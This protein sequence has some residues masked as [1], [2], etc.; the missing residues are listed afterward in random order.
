MKFLII[1]IVALSVAFVVGAKMGIIDVPGLS[2]AAKKAKGAKGYATDADPA[3][4]DGA[5]VSVSAKPADAASAGDENPAA[6]AKQPPST[7]APKSPV[8]PLAGQKSLARVWQKV[9]AST[10]ALMIEKW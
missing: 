8:D 6:A 3:K 2:P 7:A 9:D 5:S 1:V 10:I 4:K